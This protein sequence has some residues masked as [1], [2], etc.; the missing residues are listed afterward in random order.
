MYFGYLLH[1]L[2]NF[3]PGPVSNNNTSIVKSGVIGKL[4]LHFVDH[5]LDG[6]A[7]FVLHCCCHIVL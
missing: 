6:P 7:Q 2:L 3:L 5:D 1:Q 4:I